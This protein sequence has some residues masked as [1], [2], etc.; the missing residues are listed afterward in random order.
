MGTG[1]GFQPYVFGA[2]IYFPLISLFI[3]ALLQQRRQQRRNKRKKFRGGVEVMG[4]IVENNNGNSGHYIVASDTACTKNE[5]S[6][7]ESKNYPVF[8]TYL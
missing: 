2:P 1:K 7:P 4:E 8:V 5:I 6:M 3:D